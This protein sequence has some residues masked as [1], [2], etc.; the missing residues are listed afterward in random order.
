M[1]YYIDWLVGDRW[2][3]YI[4]K[5]NSIQIAT[6]TLLQISRTRRAPGNKARKRGGY[7]MGKRGQPVHIMCRATV[8]IK[9][10]LEWGE[11]VR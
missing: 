1:R 10:E 4:F 7:V 3:R 5:T 11:N 9:L 6:S 2:A 8:D